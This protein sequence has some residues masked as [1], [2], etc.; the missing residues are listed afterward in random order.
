VDALIA[1]APDLD[2]SPALSQ[3]AGQV[4]TV[5][6]N[7][8]AAGQGCDVISVA[9]FEGARDIVRHLI[10]LGHRRIATIAGP[11]HNMD[12]RQRLEGYRAALAEA[13]IERQAR[14]ELSG[15][16]TEPSGYAATRELLA[17]E[18]RHTAV[19]V[20]NDPMAIGA[21]GALEDASVMVPRDLAVVGFDDIPMAR[22]LTPPLTT[23]HV[24]LRRMGQRAMCL[25]IERDAA[26]PRGNG[27]R[28][29]LPTTLVVR[30]SCGARPPRDE[31]APK[32][33]ARRRAAVDTRR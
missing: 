26:A 9:N 11:A 29:V 1:M 15:D 28:E 32:T 22:Y 30:G 3:F 19:F 2:A 6:I 12:A 27:R 23:V 13:G 33:W 25:L 7:S 21:L 17:L 8:E 14:D 24:D 4:P 16:F 10:G 20:A 5:L 31:R 18:P